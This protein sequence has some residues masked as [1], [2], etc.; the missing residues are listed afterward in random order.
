MI[1][2]R[3]AGSGKRRDIGMIEVSCECTQQVQIDKTS[4]TYKDAIANIV[5]TAKV[6][7]RK[8]EK[9]FNEEFDK[10]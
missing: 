3:C 8:A 7:K 1:C 9:M 2:N 4:Q 10:L 5:A 6:S